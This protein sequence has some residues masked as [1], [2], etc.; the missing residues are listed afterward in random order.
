MTDKS[1][2]PK[3]NQGDRVYNHKIGKEVIVDTI[4]HTPQLQFQYLYKTDDGAS[5]VATEADLGEPPASTEDVADTLY[6]NICSVQEILKTFPGL[7]QKTA[8]AIIKERNESEFEDELSFVN[9]ML[10][11]DGKIEWEAISHKL[12]YDKKEQIGV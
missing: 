8:R 2:L 6:V 9:R 11:I 5:G 7:S 12:R 1:I 3:H 4:M 10:E